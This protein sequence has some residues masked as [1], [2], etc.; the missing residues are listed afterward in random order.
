[1]SNYREIWEQ[2]DQL[3]PDPPDWSKEWPTEPGDYWFYGYFNFAIDDDGLHFV[4]AYRHAGNMHIKADDIVV[5]CEG[6]ELLRNHTKGHWRK[7]AVPN[8]PN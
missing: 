7:A 8:R 6:I 2:I 4:Q 1:M 3:K 5:Y